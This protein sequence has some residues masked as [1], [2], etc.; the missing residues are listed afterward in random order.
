MSA[1]VNVRYGVLIITSIAK[2]CPGNF[3]KRKSKFPGYD[4][5]YTTKNKNLT[6]YDETYTPKN[7]NFLGMTKI[8]PP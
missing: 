5:I 4:E 1:T 2:P 6:R 7:K 8:T 3:G